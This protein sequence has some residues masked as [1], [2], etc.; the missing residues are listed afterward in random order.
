MYRIRL[1]QKTVFVL[2]LLLVPQ[3]ARAANIEF[4]G[5]GDMTFAETWG[6]PA[7]D[8]DAADFSSFGTDDHPL[9]QN[10]GFGN[11]GIDFVVLAELNDRLSMLSE[12]NL[13]LARGGT[14]DVGLDVERTYLDYRIN[15][16][17]NIQ[18]G[19]FFTP[20]GF[21]N[22]T[23]YS[24]AWLMYSIQIP[25]LMK[26]NWVLSRTIR[27]E[28]MCT[29]IFPHGRIIPSITPFR[30]QMPGGRIR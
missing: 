7:D 4:S 11:T 20:I 29:E 23:L 21:H 26:R 17:F 30:L 3:F 18:A 28:S 13:Q 14:S 19:S 6:G 16:G 25:T 8:A 22:R 24:R 5:F 12:V 15:N 27:P 9:S 2:V 10:N 1:L